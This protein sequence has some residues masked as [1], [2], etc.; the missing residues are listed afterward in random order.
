VTDWRALLAEI[1]VPRVVGSDNHERVRGALKG[2]LEARGFVVLEHRFAASPRAPL[3]GRPAAEAVNLVAVRPRARVAAWLTAHYD[4]K[5]QPMSMATRLL[6]AGACAGS[7]LGGLVILAA[8]GPPLAL[9]PAA[10]LAALFLGL[11]RVTERSPGATDNAAGVITVLRALDALPADAPVGVI[12]PDAEELGLQ[13]ARALVRERANLLRD[14]V[15]VNFDG[16]D[17]RGASIALVHRPGPAVDR[18]AAALGA[19]RRRRLPVLVDGIAFASAARECVT[20]MRG[21]WGTARVVHTSRD[22]ADRL[23]L[24]GSR[25]VAAAVAGVLSELR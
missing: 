14:T 18:V 17:D 13:G 7:L 2:E 24:E 15:V 16:I 5:G 4:S 6:L 23:T 21:D 3:W 8:G 12:F 10:A 1:A 19:R 22:T 11:S 9:G 25:E 20:I